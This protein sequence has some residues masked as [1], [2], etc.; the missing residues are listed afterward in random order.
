MNDFLVRC[1][2][3]PIRDLAVGEMLVEEGLGGGD[4][5]VVVRGAFAVTRGSAAVATISEPGAVIGEISALLGTEASATVVATKPSRVHVIDDPI[6]FMAEDAEG[7]LDVTRMLATRL[8]RMTS[9]LADIKRQYE[10]AGGHLDLMDEVLE[11]LT[12][13]AQE[14]VEPGSDRDPDPLY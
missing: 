10:G 1:A 11:E 4:M 5:Y 2:D 7:L 9:Y 14:S 3:L 12:F 8:Q 13:G 6:G